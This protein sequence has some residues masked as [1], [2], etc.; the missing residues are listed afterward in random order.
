MKKYFHPY[1]MVETLQNSIKAMKLGRGE[2]H[3]ID[4]GLGLYPR[5]L[6]HGIMNWT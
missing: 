2:H 5:T 4:F 6:R 3:K 1:Y